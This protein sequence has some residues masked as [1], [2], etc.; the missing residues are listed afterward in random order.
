MGNI[1]ININNKEIIKKAINGINKLANKINK[2][3]KIMHV[4]GSHEHTICKYGIREVLP[5]NITIIPG[6]GCP[7]CVT[8]QKEID[9]TIY[10]ANEGYTIAT[11]GDMYKV[12]GSSKSLMNLQSEGKDIK[13]VYG[14]SDAVKLAKN[15]PDKKVVFVAIG[16]ET[17]SPTTASEILSLDN[18]N[19]MNN[20]KINNF[21]ILNCHRQ[22]PPV[23]DFL[24]KDGNVNID[25]FICPGHVSVITGLKPYYE[26]CEKYNSPMIVAGFEPIDVLMSIF[27]IL[28]QILNNEA[29]V[30]NTYK[31]YV[32][33]EGN[34]IAQ[35]LV[36]KVFEPIDV[37][38]RG[39][40]IIKDGGLT[41]KEQ[42]KIYD[43]RNNINIPEIKE[44]INKNCICSSILKGEKL[45]T[46][47]KLFKSICTPTNPI[48]SCMV[49]D[50]GTCSI[51][52]KYRN[53]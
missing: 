16:F 51:F 37:P 24:L 48:G 41:L 39:F 25:G 36:N 44:K 26:P 42:Y 38:W 19:K 10:L 49:S 31:R 32:K 50:E 17:T 30:E 13:I 15:N 28:K 14:I 11:L 53:I 47:C 1:N 40:P 35:K 29:K 6:P 33:E 5:K 43:I 27:L 8:T 9:T 23:M 18:Y 45:P 12:P 7:V 34:I 4:C 22:T 2:D 46:D 20:E 3:I 52:Y 21:Y